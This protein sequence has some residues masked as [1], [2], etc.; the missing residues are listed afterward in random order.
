MDKDNIKFLYIFSFQFNPSFK[1]FYLQFYP[2]LLNQTL[3]LIILLNLSQI[4]FD[5]IQN[6]N[7]I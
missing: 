1:L 3:N 5:L 6:L 4:L 2:S 7:E